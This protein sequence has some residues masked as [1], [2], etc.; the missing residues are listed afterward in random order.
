[1]DVYEQYPEIPVDKY[2]GLLEALETHLFTTADILT[3]G[4]ADL[5]R[6]TGRSRAEIESFYR[7]IREAQST[8]AQKLLGSG[9]RSLDA[10][11]KEEPRNWFTTGDS[12]FDV[13][14]GGGIRTGCIT[15]LV[16]ESASGKSN[17]L[18]QLALTVQ[19]PIQCRGLNK[20]AIYLSTESGLETRRMKQMLESP[21]LAGKACSSDRILAYN[22][23][24]QD[25]LEHMIRFQVPLA[26]A[27]YNVGVIIVDSVAAHLRAEYGQSGPMLAK[28]TQSMAMRLAKLAM[29]KN[30][31][32]VAANQVTDR[33]TPN[34]Q[35]LSLAQNPLAR[36]HQAR[37]Y[38]GWSNS[39]AYNH[40]YSRR[41][42][43]VNRNPSLG[44]VWANFVSVRIALK[45]RSDF[46]TLNLVFS[47]YNRPA[48]VE[49]EI[50]AQGVRALQ[51]GNDDE[52]A[53]NRITTDDFMT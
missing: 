24:S 35:Q 16:G 20:N 18:I 47:P 17:L 34:G 15:E 9:R 42:H 22:C 14:L 30:I 45:R 36:D 33:F 19:L 49:F 32:V 26:I 40:Y 28:R 37:W 3:L 41:S 27:E 7:D 44:L 46:R 4:S 51:F 13:L 6:I 48:T 2:D 43:N 25:E 38:T 39:P 8:R 11:I 31:A 1:M 12:T 23:D 52:T 5:C 29:D 21:L 53:T 50:V 10:L